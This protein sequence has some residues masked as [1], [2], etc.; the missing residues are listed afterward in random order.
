LFLLPSASAAFAAVVCALFCS[1]SFASSAFSF[2]CSLA[3]ASADAAAC[4]LALACCFYSRIVCLFT[5]KAALYNASVM[6]S[7]NNQDC[8]TPW[9]SGSVISV[10]VL[11]SGSSCYQKNK[12]LWI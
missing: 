6:L 8:I 9:Y 3:A 7:V 1:R 4:A 2:S 5:I 11:L 10:E 12:L